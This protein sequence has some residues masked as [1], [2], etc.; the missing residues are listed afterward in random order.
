MIVVH[1]DAFDELVDQDSTLGLR[2]GVPDGLNIE[3]GQVGGDLF[4][5]VDNLS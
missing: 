4:E 1:F 3:V 5:T 2:R